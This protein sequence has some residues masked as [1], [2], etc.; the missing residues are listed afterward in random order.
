V[1]SSFSI[2]MPTTWKR[3]ALPA[4]TDDVFRQIVETLPVGVYVIGL[5]RHIGYWNKAAEQITGYLSQEVI[6]KPC[7]AEVLVH[8]GARGT[9]VCESAG[10]LLTCSL[11][12]GKS[13]DAVLYARHKDGHRVPVQVHSLPLC[14]GEGKIVGIAELFQQKGSTS[15]LRWTDSTAAPSPD[16]LSIPSTEA[17]RTYMEGKMRS[18]EGLA[19]FVVE[20]RDKNAM[21]KQ[22]GWEMVHSMTRTMVHTISDLLSQ[23]HFLGRWQGDRFVLAVPGASQESF[24]EL[25]G[26][27]EGVGNSCSVTW[28]GDRVSAQVLV[29][30]V[31]LH[32]GDS[33]E[34]LMARIDPLPGTEPEPTAR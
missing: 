30:G 16:G 6:G 32:K 17:T 15:E 21:A 29:C 19:V 23:A 24:E 7:N 22:R 25:L 8:C 5:D 11:R 34:T 27:L 18:P 2:V 26:Q 4:L 31:L 9:P 12:D 1:E 14:D 3:T 28:W 13:V 20:L 10:C 33:M